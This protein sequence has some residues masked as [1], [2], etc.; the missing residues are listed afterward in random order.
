MLNN[1]LDKLCT[2]SE[3]E[4]IPGS[5]DICRHILL[6]GYAEKGKPRNRKEITETVSILE[7]ACCSDLL[8]STLEVII[9]KRSVE[10]EK[11]DVKNVILCLGGAFNPVHTRHIQVMVEAKDWLEKNTHFRVI[12]GFLAV[13]PDG[14]VKKKC[15]KAQ[16]MCIKGE[17]RVKLCDIA[18]AEYDWLKPYQRPIGSAEDCGKKVKQEMKLSDVETA[19]IYGADRAITKS[20]TAKW[21]KKSSQVIVCI[22]R[23]GETEKVKRAFVEDKKIDLVRNDNFFIVPKELDNVSSSEVRRMLEI[24]A[25][26]D[27]EPNRVRAIKDITDLGWISEKEGQYI[28]GQFSELYLS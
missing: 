5:E 2:P 22:G 4:Y 11:K 6:D 16:Q 12:A 8:D 1:E 23:E 7:G 28:Q 25:S 24:F 10:S 14:Y 18:C 19:V 13:A 3:R 17:H 20:G 27:D 9:E 15:E 21:H 26:K